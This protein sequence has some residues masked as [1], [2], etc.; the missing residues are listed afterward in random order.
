MRT[1]AV[2]FTASLAACAVDAELPS[3][4]TTP[5]ADES[6]ADNGAVTYAT[7]LAVKLTS[8]PP[9]LTNST[10][11]TFAFTTTKPATTKCRIDGAAYAA[12]TSPVTFTGLTQ[13]L[14]LFDLKATASGKTVAIPSYRF[15]VDTT[16]PTVTITGV[17][18]PALTNQRTATFTFDA[19][20][21]VSTTCSVDT[22]PVACTSPVSYSGIIDGWHRFTVTGTDAAGNASSA[23]FDWTVDGTAPVVSGLGYSCDPNG[24]LDV[25]WNATDNYQLSGTSCSYA[26]STWDCSSGHEWTGYVSGPQTPFTVT[27]YDTANNHATKSV[28]IKSIYCN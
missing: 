15:T 18:S 16:A 21:S 14:H 28:V 17:P 27:A 24:L 11:A 5:T 22:A 26:G 10:T 25:V 2:L 8:S 4:D 13:G 12:C 19:G 6:A 3:D 20:E 1:L 9:A 7:T 23:T